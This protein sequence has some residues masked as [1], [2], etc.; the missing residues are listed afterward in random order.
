MRIKL[1]AL[2]AV[3]FLLVSAAAVARQ[4]STPA[5]RA[6][7]TRGTVST[8]IPP[9]PKGT[10]PRTPDGHPD[11]TGMY[12]GGAGEPNWMLRQDVTVFSDTHSEDTYGG[13]S[14]LTWPVRNRKPQD[15]VARG[16]AATLL[17][18]E[19]SDLPLYKPEYW[20]KVNQLDLNSNQ[21]DPAHG[22]MPDGVPRVDIPTYIGQFP[23]Y[24]IFI[25]P[26]QPAGSGYRMIPTDGRKHTPLDDLDPTYNGEGIGHWEG[27]TLV[28][29][30]WGFND[31]SWLYALESG[32]GGYFHS[33]NM[34][35]I[36][37]FHREGNTLTWSA[38][39][40]DPDVL[41]E[42]WTTPTITEALNP[43]PKAVLLGGLPCKDVAI[44]HSVTKERH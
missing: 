19:G 12:V 16:H 44:S 28:V 42:P 37:R 4:E 21:E 9:K 15:F 17:H 3:L 29:D 31:N 41:L 2:V 30:T 25:Y 7:A 34:H 5:P 1:I 38:T 39:V 10:T 23:N 24:L 11:L 22:C 43:N 26:G 20:D 14:I 33:N 6:D 8:N 36:E 13:E 35:V 40:E 32:G 27:D 18:R